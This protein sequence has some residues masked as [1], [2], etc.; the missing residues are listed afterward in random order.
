MMC[1]MCGSD[2][3]SAR[4][5]AC[6]ELVWLVADVARDRLHRLVRG[7]AVVRHGGFAGR[8]EGSVRVARISRL[9]G[10]GEAGGRSA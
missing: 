9:E 8:P 5:V 4:C 3:Q 1:A 2:A 7:G 10:L 6:E